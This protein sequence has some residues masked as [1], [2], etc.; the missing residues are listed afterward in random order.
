MNPVISLAIALATL[1][2]AP[3]TEGCCGKCCEVGANPQ[4][5]KPAAPPARGPGRM[6]DMAADRDVFHFLLEHHKD[7]TRTVKNRDD[8]VETITESDKKD[9]AAKIQEHVAAMHK[10]VK[11][12]NGIRLRDPLFAEIFKHYDK[13]EMTVEKTEKGVKVTE[14][15]KDKDVAKLIQAHAE[16]VS[17]FVKDGFDEAHKNHPV[18]TKADKKDDKK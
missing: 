16:V 14:T 13:I 3:P 11:D 7:I 6:A 8:G 4:T 17:K 5:A 2:A 12:G 9:V 10:R 1:P 15:S 18:P